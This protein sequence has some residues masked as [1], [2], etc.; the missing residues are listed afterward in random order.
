VTYHHREA[1][2]FIWAIADLLR[3]TYKAH[4]YG[5][6]ILPLVVLRRLDQALADTK[7]AVLARDAELAAQ[8]IDNREPVLRSVSKRSFYNTSP[9]TFDRLLDDEH[10]VAANLRA[11]IEA[12]S[13]NAR[14]VLDKFGFDTHIDKLDAAGLLYP[15]LGRFVDLN[16]HPDRVS[17]S[18]MGYIFEELIRRF[19][20]QSN[21]TAGEHFTPREV[22][23][24]MVELLFA[25]DWDRLNQPGQIVTMYDP[26]A[27][28]GG[29]A[30][31]GMTT[32]MFSIFTA[33][34]WLAE[35]FMDWI[36]EGFAWDVDAQI[37]GRLAELIK[38][39]VL[40]KTH[41]GPGDQ[42][43]FDAPV[44]DSRC[45]R[46]TFGSHD[47]AGNCH[48]R[49]HGSGK[50]RSVSKHVA[51]AEQRMSGGFPGFPS[52]PVHVPNII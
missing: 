2:G 15:V 25:A 34:F 51:P 41:E 7:P 44:P 21:E 42:H 9:L 50:R 11:Y 52:L 22:I 17:N 14:D 31:A 1:V 30:Q 8:G 48:S 38:A 5:D 43:L 49:C 35:R 23:A 45:M 40:A 27:G 10:H 3:G 37:N 47:F 28:T 16:L 13:P 6:V 32:A 12:F 19:A 29:T 39:P 36:D 18:D 4:D 26:A 33:I 46:R 20:E 24:L